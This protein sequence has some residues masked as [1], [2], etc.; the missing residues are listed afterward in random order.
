MSKR[1]LKQAPQAS[2]RFKPLKRHHSKP[3][4]KHHKELETKQF[5]SIVI[6]GAMLLALFGYIVFY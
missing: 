3:N 6:I 4:K 1:N 5:L 2:F